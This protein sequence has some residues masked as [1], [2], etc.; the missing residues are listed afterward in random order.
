MNA[1]GPPVEKDAPETRQS[2]STCMSSSSLCLQSLCPRQ[3]QQRPSGGLL[4]S[5]CQSMD[6]AILHLSIAQCGSSSLEET[7]PSSPATTQSNNLSDL[8]YDSHQIVLNEA[9][10]KLWGVI[11]TCSLTFLYLFYSYPHI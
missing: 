7:T 3:L 5:R 11:K 8:I 6:A 2:V 4:L 1:R 10:M 9:V